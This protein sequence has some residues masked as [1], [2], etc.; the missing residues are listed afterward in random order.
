MLTLVGVKASELYQPK[1]IAEPH[2]RRVTASEFCGAEA[3][4]AQASQPRHQAWRTITHGA[5]PSEGCGKPF[6]HWGRP[7]ALPRRSD[8]R[9]PEPIRALA[10]CRSLRA[11]RPR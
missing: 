3:R 6:M 9:P 7:P 8:T 4:L 2:G 1:P 11:G 10:I 5:I